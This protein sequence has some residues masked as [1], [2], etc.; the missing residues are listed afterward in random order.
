[1]PWDAFVEHARREL[2]DGIQLARHPALDHVLTAQGLRRSRAAAL[3]EANRLA[4]DAAAGRTGGVKEVIVGRKCAEAVLKGAE[5]YVPGVLA[6]STFIER[7]DPV[8]VLAAI[9]DP[10]TGKWPTT[11]GSTMPPF[12]GGVSED[13]PP[14]DG[15]AAPGLTG[16]EPWVA[17]ARRTLCV[18]VGVAEQGRVEMFRSGSGV[19][20]R[21]THRLFDMRSLSGVLSG[22]MVAQSL[23][24]I[25]A[26]AALGARPGETVLDMC[27]APGG[28][29]TALAEAMGN[30]GVL[31]ALDRSHGKVEGVRALCAELGI[32]MVRAL[33]MDARRALRRPGETPPGESKRKNKQRKKNKNGRGEEED[34][35]E[36]D[37]YADGFPPEHFDRIL[38]DAPCSAIGLR[39][40]L[41]Q[42]ADAAE[43]LRAAEYQR[44]FL[45]QAVQLLRP[46]GVMVFST[47]T[48]N[49][50]ENEGNVRWVLDRHACLRLDDVPLCA[51]LGGPGVTHGPRTTEDG[52]AVVPGERVRLLTDAEAMKVRR[53]TP[54]VE[55]AGRVEEGGVRRAV[56]GFFIARFV[57]ER[58]GG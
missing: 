5:A 42:P 56:P 48:I 58:G 47:C 20:V 16:L 54:N 38:V 15:D 40:R 6:C 19:A 34:A 9:E 41:L 23:P 14:R 7:G 51:S 24:S 46:G 4:A 27:A 53:F 29:T 35:A 12:R 45:E 28:K 57:K 30:M 11:R 13:S 26:A 17:E 18:G 49:P 52:Q 55:E 10:A 1:M 31:Y 8:V 36:R 2:G 22:L 33:R 25:A 3:T 50:L 37:E 32:T 21:L 39:P 43:L 44:H